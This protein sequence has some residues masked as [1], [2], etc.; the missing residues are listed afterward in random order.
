[1]LAVGIA[2]ADTYTIGTGTSTSST[3]PFYGT[4]NYG[5]CKTI[6][7]AG[8]INAAGLAAA[9]EII[10]IGFYVGNTPVNYSMENQFVYLRHTATSQYESTDTNYPGNA[11]HTLVFHGDITYNGS[12]WHYIVFSSPF[13]WD[14]T[15]NL[16]FLYEN[17]DTNNPTGY[18]TFRYTSTSTAYRTVYK[19]N[20][21]AFPDT[22]TGSRTYSRANIQLITTTTTAP[23]AASVVYPLNWATEISPTVNLSWAPG[24][25]W[26]DGY[27]LSLGTDNPPSN[28]LDSQDQGNATSYNPTPDLA[29]NT[30]YYWKITPYN[31]FGDAPDCPVWSF[32][33]HGTNSI[34]ALPYY[35]QF[36]AVAAPAL[37]YNWTAIVQASVT[38]AL[39]VTYTTSPHTAPNCVRLYNSTD[40]AANVILVGPQI[41]NNLNLNEIRVRFFGKGGTTYHLQVGV[42][43]NPTDPTT[44]VSVQDLNVV[45][46][47]NEYTVSLASYTGTGRYIAFKHGCAASS[48][49]LY[50]DD[51][52]F[53]QIAPCDLACN[54]VIGNPTPCVGSNSVYQARIYNWGTQ[55]QTTYTVKLFKANNVELATAT[56]LSVEPGAE[57]MVP[58]IWAPTTVE[59]T[60]IYAKVFITG[61]N[62]SANDQSPILNI[63]VQPAGVITLPIGEGNLAE[64]VPLEF[65]YKNSLHQCI[66]YQSELNVFGVIS[67]I[68][69]FNNFQTNLPDKPCK[70]WLGQTDL[71]DLSAGWILNGLTLVFDGTI[72][73][74]NGENAITIPLQTPFAYTSGNLVLYA[75]RPWDTQY[76]SSNDNF[77]AQTIGTNRARKL[78]SDSV[79][80]D[81]AAPS[82]AG[83]LSGTFAMTSFSFSTSVWGSLNGTVTSGGTPVSGVNIV[84]DGTT[85][86]TQTNA[87]GAYNFPIVFPGNYT[88]TAS[89]IGFE[90]LTLP[91]VILNEQTITLDF[92]LVAST[93][94]NVFGVVVGSDAPT[95][96]LE[97]ATISLSGIQNYSATTNA[98]GTFTIPGVL[99]GNSYAYSISHQGYQDL[100]G[101]IVV[102]TTDCNMGSLVLSEIALPPGQVVATENVEQTQVTVVWSHPGA[103]GPGMD[104]EQNDGGWVPSSNWTNPLGDFQWTN[105]YNV[106]NYVTGQ[107]PNSEF[108]PQTAHSGTGLWGTVLYAPYS[109]S[110]GYSYLTK[111]VS[112]AGITNPQMRFWSWN[113]SFGNWDYGQVAVNGNIV[114]GPAW[115]TNPV[116][117]EEVVIDISAF[118]NLA[119]VTIQF[120]HFATTVVSY[121]GWYIDD[122]YL[123][124]AQATATCNSIPQA[125]RYA[126]FSELQAANLTEQNNRLNPPAQYSREPERIVGYKV[127][128]LLAENQTNEVM[129]MML[130][131][132]AITDT[133]FV[134]LSWAPLPSGVYKY[135][136]KAVYTNNVFSAPV[137]SNELHKGM[138]GVLTGNVTEFGTNNPISGATITAGDYSGTSDAQGQYSFL[139]YA[140][141]YNVICSKAGYQSSTQPGIVITGT[142][143]TTQNFV[144]TEITL[145]PSAVQAEEA[146]PNVNV[147]WLAPGNTDREALTTGLTKQLTSTTDNPT[148][149]PTGFKVWRLQ[150]QQE[151]NENLWSSLTPTPITATNYVDTAWS[152][153]PYD[154]YKWAVKAVYSGGA[155]SNPSFSNVLANIPMVGTIAGIVRNLQNQPLPGTTIT[156]GTTTA[157]TNNSGAYSLQ[158][159]AGVHSVTASHPNYLPVTHDNITVV[160]GQTTTVNFQLSPSAVEDPNLSPV[161]ATELKGNY[162]NP[163]NPSTSIAFSIKDASPVK[164]IVYNLQGKVIKELL[165]ETLESGHYSLAW[166]GTDKHGIPAASGVYYYKLTAGKYSSTRKMILLK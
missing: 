162:P 107:Y 85:S 93:S 116:E 130:T 26:P 121:A 125:N 84:I 115:D 1:L 37:P 65:Y 12:G 129:W 75:N 72:S 71:N 110:G 11:T 122:V 154:S 111:E 117:W 148:R 15:Q 13:S 138:M 73:F 165:Q 113:N 159:N 83:T 30:T 45:A 20:D 2:F 150:S 160:A 4:Y 54:A 50:V 128:R 147:T 119:N 156:C 35:Q 87:A 136:V 86:H 144:L 133:S 28:I 134:D 51:V 17:L 24:S 131:A 59:S 62:N 145:P 38:T 66:Y 48:Q 124:P 163:F 95:T 61:D 49:S 102:G 140:G 137:F 27:K 158:V 41:E 40:T 157:T 80:Y 164:L 77:R 89:K 161:V 139:V 109:L 97:G 16:E 82:A 39:A 23:D 67:A 88:V 3:N 91:V 78:Y 53:E 101:T 146:Y 43:S 34:G 74:P 32:T 143:T 55:I 44:F 57:V 114:W 18:P 10:G 21:T 96:G 8:E 81:P 64:G 103:I 5:W 31:S 92:S 112:F 46:N 25:I 100:S 118:A 152:T 155:M 94:V 9:T 126:G 105:T 132:N 127:W 63:Y 56:G 47:W 120:Q 151:N 141:T 7:T 36:D 142:Q 104:F 135:A 58:L 42:I 6:Y 69:F 14:G 79:T 123:G 22:G 153:L 76:F 106:S 33:T 166:D 90:S 98:T 60:G 99:S 19:G 68:T 70:F 149:I 52:R 29:I 108:P